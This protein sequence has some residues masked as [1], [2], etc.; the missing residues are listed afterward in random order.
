ML[1]TFGTWYGFKFDDDVNDWSHLKCDCGKHE[2]V[3]MPF[4]LFRE[5]VFMDEFG[6]WRVRRQVLDR[7]SPPGKVA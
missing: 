6:R 7:G 5:G 4:K 2:F 1:Q 3:R